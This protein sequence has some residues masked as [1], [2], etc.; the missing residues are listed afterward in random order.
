MALKHKNDKYP[1]RQPGNE[2]YFHSGKTVREK[3]WHTGVLCSQ[4]GTIY[5]CPIVWMSNINTCLPQPKPEPIEQEEHSERDRVQ[6]KCAVLLEH[7]YRARWH[8]C[9]K[10]SP[11]QPS[12]SREAG[13]RER[14]DSSVT[15][16]WQEQG[17]GKAVSEKGQRAMSQKCLCQEVSL[18]KGD[19]SKYKGENV[20]A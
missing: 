3:D 16:I 4:R 2:K 14:C 8:S 5:T 7:H 13:L 15:V 12:Q 1:K 9:R 18:G 17:T 6:I 11:R 19:R 10:S 20:T